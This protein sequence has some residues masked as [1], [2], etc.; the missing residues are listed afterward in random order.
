MSTEISTLQEQ[1]KERLRGQMAGMVPDEIWTKMIDAEFH[2]VFK[3]LITVK[4]PATQETQAMTRFQHMIR[5]LIVKDALDK[6]KVLVNDAMHVKYDAL[7]N[8]QKSEIIGEAIKQNIQGLMASVMSAMFERATF[9][10]LQ[11]MRNGY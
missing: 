5:E 2:H 4:D 8:T 6:A 11:R 7:T 10:A 1:M 3:E 9:D